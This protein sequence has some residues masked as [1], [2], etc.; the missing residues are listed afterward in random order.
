MLFRSAR[1]IKAAV[2]QDCALVP[3]TVHVVGPGWLVKTTSGKLSRT[4]N[5]RKYTNSLLAIAL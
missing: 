3:R 4:D 1:S 2:A 5:L